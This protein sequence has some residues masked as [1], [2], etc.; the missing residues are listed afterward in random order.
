MTLPENLPSLSREALVALVVEQQRQITELTAVIET[1]RAELAQ[2]RRDAKRQAAPFSKGT[3]AAAPKRPGRQPGSGRCCS[4]EAP[5]PDQITGPPVEVPVTLTAC[6]DCGGTLVTERL[7][8]VSTT[9]RPPLPRPQ[10]TQYHVAVRRCLLCGQ[11]VRGQHPDVAS[12]HYGAT[13]HRVGAR[14]MAAAHGRHSGIGIP[15]RNVPRVLEALTGVTLTQGALT[16][17]A[18][19]RAAHGVGEV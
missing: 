11:Q 2:L 8:V 16:Q 14:V 10:V 4:R 12:D 9:D 6:P 18:L 19:R 17:D 5:R 1:L 15:V 13:A 3:R 7:D